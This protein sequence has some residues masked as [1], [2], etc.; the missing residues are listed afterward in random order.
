MNRLTTVSQPEDI[1]PRYRNTPIGLL[2]EYHNLQ[3]RFDM[4]FRPT[5][6]SNANRRHLRIPEGFMYKV[7]AWASWIRCCCSSIG[8]KICCCE[9]RSVV[10]GFGDTRRH[11]TL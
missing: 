5:F 7:L 8:K 11:P 10:T 2:L 1:F 3:R 4:C 9:H 6:N